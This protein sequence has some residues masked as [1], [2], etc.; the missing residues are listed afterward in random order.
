[1]VV[2]NTPKDA[3]TVKFIGRIKHTAERFRQNNAVKRRASTCQ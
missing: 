1:M 2:R 3:V